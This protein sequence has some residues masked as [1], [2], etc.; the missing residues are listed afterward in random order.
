MVTHNPRLTTYASRVITMLDGKVDVKGSYEV[1]HKAIETFSSPAAAKAWAR[2]SPRPR[3]PRSRT[4][5]STCTSRW[6]SCE[7][8]PT[9]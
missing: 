4:P 6:S 9:G 3:A 7:I 5:G 1:V 8:W 2:R